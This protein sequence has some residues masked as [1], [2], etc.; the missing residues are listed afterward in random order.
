MSLILRLP[1]LLLEALLLL[2]ARAAHALLRRLRGEDR[3]REAPVVDYDGSLPT[4]DE[5]IERRFRREAAAPPPTPRRPT[6]C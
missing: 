2:P 4:A 3:E 5:A 6:A 1:Q